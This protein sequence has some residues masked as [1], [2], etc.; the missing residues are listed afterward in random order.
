VVKLAVG[1]VME[2]YSYDVYG[3]LTSAKTW[4]NGALGAVVDG[5]F[6]GDGAIDTGATAD[7]FVDKEY[8]ARSLIDKNSDEGLGMSGAAREQLSRRAVEQERPR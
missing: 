2:T 6:D 8:F 3:R 7:G 5:D 4:R 1:M